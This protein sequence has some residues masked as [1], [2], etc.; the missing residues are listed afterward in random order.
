MRVGSFMMQNIPLPRFGNILNTPEPDR[1]S[2]FPPDRLELS[3]R[4][5]TQQRQKVIESAKKHLSAYKRQYG[6]Q[7]KAVIIDIDDTLLDDT[8]LHKQYDNA[9]Q[10][11]D[12][13]EPIK[14]SL[15]R[16]WVNSAQI[17]AI[18][19]V[20]DFVRWAHQEG[21]NVMF[22]SARKAEYHE[23]TQK[24][25]SA[26]GLESGHDYEK[27]YTKSTETET[28]PIREFKSQIYQTITQDGFDIAALVA[29]QSDDQGIIPS[30][31]FFKLPSLY[32]PA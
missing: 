27:L 24:N 21:F 16:A 15:Y 4:N 18:P 28:L 19:E 32:Q 14:R 22:V 2:P 7:H 10:P 5:L 31:R 25:L 26:V 6:S 30:D 17:P 29:D 1:V 11:P 9:I 3:S 12:T 20:L 23:V 8:E 13:K